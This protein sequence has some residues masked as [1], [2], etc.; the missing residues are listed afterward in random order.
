MPCIESKNNFL[1]LGCIISC[2][3]K[4]TAFYLKTMLCKAKIFSRKMY[5][6]GTEVE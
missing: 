6:D 5:W 4:N 2:R 1:K 3:Q